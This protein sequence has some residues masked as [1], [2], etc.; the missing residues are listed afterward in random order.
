MNKIAIGTIYRSEIL[1]FLRTLT[2]S[3][4]SPVLSAMLYFIVFG[5]AIGPRV[6]EVGGVSYGQFIV[7]GIIMLTVM[8]QS[9]SNAAFGIFFPKFTRTTYE[10]LS[11]PVDFFEIM[12]GYVGAA[13]TKSLSIGLVILVAANFFV[14]LQIEYPII[15]VLLLVL[16][17]IC[18][19]LFG[20]II[21]IWANN[22]EQLQVIPL[23]LVTPLVFLGGSFYSLKDLPPVWQTITLFN[24]VS[25]LISGFRWTFF[26]QADVPVV[27]SLLA[28]GI[29]SLG[30]I[31]MIWWIFRTGWRLRT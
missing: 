29:F 2:Q 20:F 3:F 21:G 17:C 19:A 15:M 22:F 5:A 9:I 6:Q 23:M 18:F 10:L 31:I 26:G 25:Y 27:Y 14:D 28:L 1:R 30:C 7:P 12:C 24:P 4:L 13:A 8:T 16:T 11:A